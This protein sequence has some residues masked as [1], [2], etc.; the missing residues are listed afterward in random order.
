[1]LV[2]CFFFW[3]AFFALFV[4]WFAISLFVS[5]ALLLY[6]GLFVDALPFC[7]WFGLLD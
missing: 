7:E 2:V 4:H 3:F 5:F 1:M 6:F